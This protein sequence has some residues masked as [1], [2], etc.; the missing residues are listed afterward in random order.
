MIMLSDEE[1]IGIRD[2]LLHAFQIQYNDKWT[3]CLTK[4]LKPSPYESIAEKYGVSKKDVLYVKHQIWIWGKMMK[5]LGD[6]VNE[7]IENIDDDSE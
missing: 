1:F 3:D 2:D 6:V 5:V 4:N 7:D